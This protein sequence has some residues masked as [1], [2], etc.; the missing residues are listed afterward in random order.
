MNEYISRESVNLWREVF[1]V[2]S[3]NQSMDEAAAL[4]NVA[5]DA[6]LAKFQGKGPKE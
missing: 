3:V 2:E 5:V 4:A 1:R 6:F